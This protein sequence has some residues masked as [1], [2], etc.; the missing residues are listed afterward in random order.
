MVRFVERHSK[1][2]DEKEYHF[3][4]PNCKKPNFFLLYSP[5][6][7]LEC[8]H[9]LPEFSA[10]KNSLAIRVLWHLKKKT[11]GLAPKQG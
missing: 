10:L 8:F 9:P 7:C 1:Y 4:C 2:F 5:D 6:V 11:K 3:T